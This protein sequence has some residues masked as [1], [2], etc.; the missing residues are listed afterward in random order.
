MKETVNTRRL[1]ETI[2]KLFRNDG[3]RQGQPN[4]KSIKDM[5][6][7]A[8]TESVPSN[9]KRKC[10][11]K[12]PSCIVEV[13]CMPK[14][15]NV[16]PREHYKEKLQDAGMI[17]YLSYQKSDSQDF[18]LQKIMSLFSQVFNGN[19]KIVFLDGRTK[20]LLKSFTPPSSYTEWNGSAI[21]SLV[22][23]GH[24]YILPCDE[25]SS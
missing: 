14:E 19:K 12:Q 23:Q 25:V 22:G 15:T 24:L 6:R 13:V 18:I 4:T 10:I 3:S 16:I 5:K 21:A 11:D 2:D 7:K 8:C 1:S 17:Q 9:N 20:H